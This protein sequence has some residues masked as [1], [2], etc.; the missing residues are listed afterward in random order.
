[1]GN[2]KDGKRSHHSSRYCEF[3]YI[4][5]IDPLHHVC[6][7]IYVLLVKLGFKITYINRERERD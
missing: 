3:I 7:T 4:L 2:K 5:Y 6:K 1:M